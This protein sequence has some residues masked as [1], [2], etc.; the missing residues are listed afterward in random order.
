MST[1]ERLRVGLERNAESFTPD[2]FRALQQVQRRRSKVRPL[3]PLLGIAAAL[4]TIGALAA[5][6]QRPEGS[7]NTSASAPTKPGTAIPS[8]RFEADIPPTDNGLAGL[9]GRWYITL[10]PDGTVTVEPPQRAEGT[11]AT[12]VTT[13]TGHELSIDLSSADL[14]PGQPPGRYHWSIAPWGDLN[15]AV[16]E[17]SCAV[18]TDLLTGQRRTWTASSPTPPLTTAR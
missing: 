16:L 9:S 17:D 3:G 13:L 15:L 14:C 2:V 11:V 12:L 7:S 1:E 18:R 6:A 4:V 8:Q 10:D 5:I